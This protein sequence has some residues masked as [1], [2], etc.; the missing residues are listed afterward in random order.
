[1]A[2]W[3]EQ[4]KSY[5]EVNF[6]PPSYI[7]VTVAKNIYVIHTQVFFVDAYMNSKADPSNSD[8]I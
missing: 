2:G 4:Y 1:M 7:W 6:N 8:T 3:V 5:R